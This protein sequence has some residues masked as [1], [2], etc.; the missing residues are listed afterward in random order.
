M[1]QFEKNYLEY[2]QLKGIGSRDKVVLSRVVCVIS[3]ICESLSRLR[4]LS[5]AVE[6]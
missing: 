5:K 6:F 1:I 3:K 2:I 4:N